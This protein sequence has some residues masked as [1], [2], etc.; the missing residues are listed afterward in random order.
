MMN[1]FRHF[2]PELL[3]PPLGETDGDEY[4]GKPFL[5]FFIT[6]LM[7]V[8]KGKKQSHSFYSMAE[9]NEWRESLQDEHEIRRWNVKYYKGLGT[10][11]PAEAKEYFSAFDDH[12]RP[13]A[14]KSEKDGE[15]LDMVFDKRRASDRRDWINTEYNEASNISIDTADGNSVT[16][17]DFVNNEMIHFS[18]ADNVRSIPSVI[19]GLKPSQRKVL[20]ACFKRNLKKEMK[21]A[22][23]AGYCAEHTAYHHGEASLHATSELKGWRFLL[24]CHRHIQ[25]LTLV[26]SPLLLRTSSINR[27]VIG[28]AQDFVG[29]NNI[30]LLVPS[31][32]F[33]TRLAGGK[34]AAS[35]RYIFT[36]LSPAARLLFPEADDALLSYMED[37]GQSI[38]PEVFCPIIPLLLVN[39]AQGIGTGWSTNIP[40]HNPRDVLAYIRAKLDGKHEL[41]SLQPWVR[42]FEGDVVAK[43]DGRGYD[44]IGKI[45]KAT[46]SSV[47]I[48]E[49]PIGKWTNDYKDHL[50]R[51]RDK[52]TIQNILEDHTTTSVAFTVGMRSAQFSRVGSRST[53]H[54][55]FKLALWGVIFC[56]MKV[57]QGINASHYFLTRVGILLMC[58]YE[59][60]KSH[61]FTAFDHNNHTIVDAQEGEAIAALLQTE[62][63]FSKLHFLLWWWVCFLI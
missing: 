4:D 10:S 57:F 61:N 53:L 25:V 21:V 30:N 34:D 5:S 11:T 31:G 51:M 52:G 59:A 24:Q 35:P 12:H 40:P 28:M 63:W 55:H 46:S 2:W 56:D 39:G 54:K 29:S 33:G 36:A 49:L 18:N 22:Q 41:P 45:E 17:E 37:D 47:V 38:E 27:A 43:G 1:F 16:F 26:S 44:S 50:L 60:F 8:T 9:Y 42:G 48:S 23:L 15:L 6:P 14:W 13:F 3:K 7:K 58:T 20:F 62:S 32:Q 19:D